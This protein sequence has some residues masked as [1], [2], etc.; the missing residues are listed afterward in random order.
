M[1]LLDCLVAFL[2]V[3]LAAMLVVGIMTL[4][5]IKNLSSSSETAQTAR[6]ERAVR[7]P[8]SMKPGIAP[9][10]QEEDLIDLSQVNFDEGYDAI[11]AYGR[12]ES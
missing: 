12:G 9:K 1:I 11:A 5:S 6:Y 4:F 2:A 8:K 7:T 10:Q 3:L